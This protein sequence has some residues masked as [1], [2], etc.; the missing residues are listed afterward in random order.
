MKFRDGMW[1]V[2]EDK[3]PEYAEEVY[4]IQEHPAGNALSLLCPT[5]RILQRSDSLNLP[6][7]TIVRNSQYSP[8]SRKLNLNRIFEHLSTASSQSKLH[9]GS[10]PSTQVLI[11]TSTQQANPNNAIQQSP[12]PQ[13]PQLSNQAPSPPQSRLET[14]TLTSVSTP[15]TVRKNSPR[16]STAAWGSRIVLDLETKCRRVTC[17]SCNITS[18]RRVHFLWVSRCMVLVSGLV[19]SIR[20]VRLL[21]SGTR[22]VERAVIR[23]IK[24]CLSG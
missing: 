22:M 16:C 20:W 8:R 3:R 2:A 13:P 7:L 19:L 1:M 14:M 24:M 15:Q 21:R 23:R 4:S 11:S 12:R 10:A 18:S 6:T 5:K 17:P 9:I